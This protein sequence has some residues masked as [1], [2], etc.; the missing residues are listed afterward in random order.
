MSKPWR[1]EKVRRPRAAVQPFVNLLYSEMPDGIEWY[2]GG[3]WRRGALMVGDLDVVII[4]ESGTLPSTSVSALLSGFE[5][6]PSVTYQRRG[7]KIAQG[8]LT[9]PGTRESIHVDFWGCT[10]QERGA[11]L[12]FI[13]GPKDLN[14]AQRHRAKELGLSL[15]Q[16][17]LLDTDR[18]Q[19][20]DGTEEDIYRILG[21]TYLSP[22]QRQSF[23]P[24]EDS[25]ETITR[26]VPSSS[27]NGIY[28]VKIR[29]N[30]VRCTCKGFHYRQM[31]KHVVNL[32][33]ELGFPK[34]APVTVNTAL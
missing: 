24:P 25:P 20:D 34:D 33:L 31:C 30:Q 15:S 9:L 11:F 10:P 8:D 1:Q 2:L 19:V 28:T 27:G 18:N 13:T 32:R 16:I 29:G 14:V 5:L 23:A 3:S 26:Q 4:T 17:G 22:E 7:L 21:H 12:L 6:P